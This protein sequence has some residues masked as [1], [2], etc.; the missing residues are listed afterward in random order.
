MTRTGRR[1][2]RQ[3]MMRDPSSARHKRGGRPDSRAFGG[4]IVSLFDNMLLAAFTNYFGE[5]AVPFLS[6]S[7]A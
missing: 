3:S 6:A 5:S 1:A 7:L 4:H 2:P